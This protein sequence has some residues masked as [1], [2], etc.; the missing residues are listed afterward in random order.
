MNEHTFFFHCDH[1]GTRM[2]YA[3]QLPDD[4]AAA[5]NAAHNPGT[6]EVTRADGSRVW[7]LPVNQQ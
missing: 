1:Y 7:P 3:V 4:E 5:E 6:R 2:V